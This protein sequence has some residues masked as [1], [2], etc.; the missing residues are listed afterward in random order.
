MP[1]LSTIA[2]LFAFA[3]ASVTCGKDS[4]ESDGNSLMMMTQVN[5]AL[6]THDGEVEVGPF[7]IDAGDEEEAHSDNCAGS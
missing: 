6:M 4:L 3:G 5:T 1:R 7:D 2:S